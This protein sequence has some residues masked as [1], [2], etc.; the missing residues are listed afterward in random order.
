MRPPSTAR[1][2]ALPTT[3][4]HA[5][6][7]PE[8]ERARVPKCSDQAVPRRAGFAAAVRQPGHPRTSSAL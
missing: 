4:R 8:D 6:A 7:R 2:D 3:W 1:E 5:P